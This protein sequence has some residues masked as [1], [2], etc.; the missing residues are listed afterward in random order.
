MFQIFVND[1][2]S[3]QCHICYSLSSTFK[4]AY[5]QGPKLACVPTFFYHLFIKQDSHAF[6]L[7]YFYCFYFTYS[8]Y[9]EHFTIEG[10]FFFHFSLSGQI[11]VAKKSFWS[12][13]H[14]ITKIKR[15]V[16]AKTNPQIRT[17]ADVGCQT[18]I[19]KKRY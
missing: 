6:T 19:T 7:F 14:I 2:T 1:A 13:S 4:C 10:R 11:E 12:V 16:G 8:V 9:A 5:I 3:K 18:Y 15:H 17:L